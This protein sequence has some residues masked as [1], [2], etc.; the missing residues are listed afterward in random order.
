M[1]EN[2]SKRVRVREQEARERGGERDDSETEMRGRGEWQ[3]PASTSLS[4]TRSSG[5]ITRRWCGACAA[6]VLEPALLSPWSQ[7]QLFFGAVLF[8]L[9][10]LSFMVP[11]TARRGAR[12]SGMPAWHCRAEPQPWC[13][14]LMASFHCSP[15]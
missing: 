10:F 3:R 2:E 14:R 6:F 15:P 4:V 11:S 1:R 12:S 9:S 8:R 5:E 13:N 7:I